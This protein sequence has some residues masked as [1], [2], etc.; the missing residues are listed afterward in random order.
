[1]ARIAFAQTG[2]PV[3]RVC[4][5]TSFRQEIILTAAVFSTRKA[6]QQYYTKHK[7]ILEKQLILPFSALIIVVTVAAATSK[8]SCRHS[9]AGLIS[10]NPTP[11]SSS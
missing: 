11:L 6:V 2:L 1:M 9:S 10:R 3:T 8:I 4:A 5:A 7:N